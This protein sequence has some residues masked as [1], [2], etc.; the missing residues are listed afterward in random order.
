MTSG[1]IIDHQIL[2]GL[3]HLQRGHCAYC[4]GAMPHP[5]RPSKTEG[6]SNPTKD[7]LLPLAR[8]GRD[9]VENR[10]AACDGCNQDKGPL[11]AATFV[12]VRLNPVM[13]K[14]ARRRCDAEVRAAHQAAKPGSHAR[15]T[16]VPP[17]PSRSD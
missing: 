7:H 11:D 2:I 5:D 1:P 15:A 4:G 13:L 14:E 10:V 12:R 6:R 9:E 3:W 16:A 8:G 17:T